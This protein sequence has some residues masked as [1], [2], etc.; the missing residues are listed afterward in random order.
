MSMLDNLERSELLTYDAFLN[1]ANSERLGTLLGDLVVYLVRGSIE[2][3]I[4]INGDD[5]R[6]PSEDDSD[7]ELY[8]EL[9][10][11]SGC[12]VWEE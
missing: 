7:D 1:E 11:C 10:Y 8:L 2:R 9:D 12:E 5:P 6:F 3:E 4:F